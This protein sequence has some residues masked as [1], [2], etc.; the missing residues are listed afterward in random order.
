MRNKIKKIVSWLLTLVILITSPEVVK[1]DNNNNEGKMWRYLGGGGSAVHTVRFRD[2]YKEEQAQLWI[3][4]IDG[5]NYNSQNNSSYLIM[6]LEVE[7]TS[8]TADSVSYYV[9]GTIGGNTEIYAHLGTHF[10]YQ[11]GRL[12]GI[13][14]FQAFTFPLE[15]NSGYVM[16]GAVYMDLRLIGCPNGDESDRKVMYTTRGWWGRA[17]SGAD[18]V[19]GANYSVQASIKKGENQSVNYKYGGNVSHTLSTTWES[20]LSKLSGSNKQM[21]LKVGGSIANDYVSKEY[22][23][24]EDKGSKVENLNINV[25]GVK[26]LRR[27]YNSSTNELSFWYDVSLNLYNEVFIDGQSKG[28]KQ[29]EENAE[30]GIDVTNELPTANLKIDCDLDSTEDLYTNSVVTFKDTSEDYENDIVAYYLKIYGESGLVGSYEYVN[31]VDHSINN[32][33]RVDVDNERMSV[34]SAK[35]GEQKFKFLKEGP[36]QVVYN[37]IDGMYAQS[38]QVYDIY[39]YDSG[40]EAHPPVADFD[41]LSKV[42][43]GD[44]VRVTST[45]TDEDNDIVKYEWSYDYTDLPVMGEE[46]KYFDIVYNLAGVYTISHK[47]TDSTGLYDIVTKT[48]EVVDDRVV[49]PP[50]ADFECLEEIYEGETLRVTS[51][52]K[53]P[54]N[55]IVLYAWQMQNTTDMNPPVYGPNNMY[56]DIT[57][58]H[59]GRY[60]ITHTVYDSNGQSSTIT[61]SV[62]VK[63]KSD[64][65]SPPEAIFTRD[66]SNVKVG[67][68]V[69]ITSTSTDP[70]NDIVKYLWEINTNCGVVGPIY[71]END[72]YFDIKFKTSG[73][74]LVKHMVIDSTGNSDT[75]TSMFPVSENTSGDGNN[76]P[77]ADFDYKDTIRTGTTMRVTEKA[78]DLDNDIVKYEWLVEKCSDADRI[79]YS[80]DGKYVDVTYFTEG[81][82]KITLK[83]TDSR[84]NTDSV[85]KKVNVKS[86]LL[87]PPSVTIEGPSKVKKG[88]DVSLKAIAEDVDGQIV[89]YKWVLPP[90]ATGDIQGKTSGVVK[91]DNVGIATVKV[92]VKDNDGLEG[93]YTKVINVVED[94]KNPPEVRIEGPITAN[95]NKNIILAA[96]ASDSDGSIVDYD[97]EWDS[98]AIADLDGKNTGIIKFSTVGVH[99]VKVTVTDNDGLT[100]SATTA[101]TVSKAGSPPIADFSMPSSSIIGD[102]VDIWTTSTDPD[103]DIVKNEWWIDGKV[104]TELN[105]TNGGKYTFDKEGTYSIKLKV[106]DS[107]GSTDSITKTIT[108]KYLVP[109]IVINNGESELRGKQ[110]RLLILDTSKSTNHDKAGE[111]LWDETKWVFQKKVGGRYVSTND[112]KIDNTRS[113]NKAL[114]FMSKEV[115]TY[116]GTVTMKNETGGSDS[117]SIPIYILEDEAPRGEVM[118]V[119]NDK[120]LVGKGSNYVTFYTNIESYDGDYVYDFEW[121]L[122]RDDNGD[123]KFT[124]DERISDSLI[125]YTNGGRS[126]YAKIEKS[127]GYPLIKV[128]VKGTETFGGN[129]IEEYINPEDYR[130]CIVSDIVELNY[131]PEVDIEVDGDTVYEDGMIKTYYGDEIGLTYS[132]YDENTAS[133][134]LEWKV[135]SMST[136]GISY[137]DITNSSN[138]YSM[139]VKNGKIK[140]TF[141]VNGIYI[142][143]GIATDER[144]LQGKAQIKVRVYKNPVAELDDVEKYRYN[145]TVFSVKQFLRMDI[146]SNNSS[147]DDEYGD[148]WHPID[149]SKDEFTITALDKQGSDAIRVLNDTGDGRLESKSNS[150]VS[151]VAKGSRL[152]GNGYTRSFTFTKPGRYKIAYQC[153]NTYGRKSEVIYKVIN[154]VQDELPEVN[155]ESLGKYYRGE[156]G[157]PA[158]MRLVGSRA[159]DDTSKYLELNS[160]D[161]DKIEGVKVK[162]KYDKKNNNNYVLVK[163]LTE[164]Y[165][166]T[167]Y[168]L[169][170]VQGDE[171]KNLYDAYWLTKDIGKYKVEL[172]AVEVPRGEYI[173]VLL[174]EVPKNDMKKEFNMELDNQ[175]PSATYNVQKKQK[176]DVL[177]VTGNTASAGKLK[178]A[179]SVI[180]SSLNSASNNIDAQVSVKSSTDKYNY[181]MSFTQGSSG[182]GDPV[183]DN[184]NCFGDTSG[185]NKHK[186]SG[187]DLIFTGYHVSNQNDYLEG[188]LPSGEQIDVSFNVDN[189]SIYEHPGGVLM[190][191]VGGTSTNPDYDITSIKD[192]VHRPEDEYNPEGANIVIAFD[193]SRMMCVVGDKR[194]VKS[195]SKGNH[196]V[197]IVVDNET[198]TTKV[199]LNDKLVGT[200]VASDLVT[201]KF[202]VVMDHIA[203]KCDDCSSATIRNFSVKYTKQEYLTSAL[204][205]MMWRSGALKFIIYAEDGIP[206]YMEYMSSVYKKYYRTT[207]GKVLENKAHVLILGSATNSEVM[208]EFIRDVSI[209]DK[210]YMNS[211][212][213]MGKLWYNTNN[214]NTNITTMCEYIITIAKKVNIFTGYVLVDDNLTWDTKY[215]DGENDLALNNGRISFDKILAERWRFTHFENYFDNSMGKNSI[216]GIWLAD[217]MDKASKVGLYRINYKRKDN[218]F[219]PDTSISN[220]FNEYRKWSTDYD[221]EYTVGD[222]EEDK[223]YVVIKISAKDVGLGVKY[224]LLPN[225]KKIYSNEYE[226]KVYRNGRYTFKVVDYSGKESSQTIVVDSF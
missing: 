166:D 137:K 122:Y 135:Y 40:D 33:E 61:K 26:D 72:V 183:L 140:S 54:D 15:C 38:T 182:S 143:E 181:T 28:K 184:G 215:K 114:Y 60:E 173:L 16:D 46:N 66:I 25:D 102:E 70:D 62:V 14:N 207:V 23:V 85:T 120:G 152:G 131:P 83:V 55:D 52:A 47:V 219:Y 94:A 160:P 191:K 12:G 129:T 21:K 43:V 17:G 31:F 106:T 128:V 105:Y 133:T 224:I 146:H 179:K 29:A 77:I 42:S 10:K 104:F 93:E 153:V 79:V 97:W 108:V 36:Y 194:Y 45:S 156:G 71:G 80:P 188:R 30:L 91:F 147:G 123:G 20:N 197:N 56:F 113:T 87:S 212:G 138:I 110:N 144:G 48:I 225:G 196:K 205:D 39:V 112:I 132:I 157:T 198:D 8:V 5:S 141:M 223:D 222:E 74:V 125:N 37:I 63:S 65:S 18:T 119:E 57:Y 208:E 127:G 69:R 99:Y 95:V 101:I 168:S 107:E 24:T 103:N 195:V 50:V 158:E 98:S 193:N 9:E 58:L 149:F 221:G 67:D 154:V 82:Y 41:C 19:T 49:S 177:I 180:E 203:H 210:D 136:N 217:A 145:N 11:T 109:N 148:A 214:F 7:S 187:D 186:V 163:E 209:G 34:V 206:A 218:P 200:G 2:G 78:F 1:A 92:I 189:Q 73:Y 192:M 22:T 4:N 216:S 171:C 176:V 202:K 130:Y 211:D 167:T 170:K 88:E 161:G 220:P 174:D 142:I 59:A 159:A 44:T 150:K 134:K 199:Y 32:G 162:I 64:N 155:V 115:G 185:V 89:E 3:K 201:N 169:V 68:T 27:V 121:E 139:S 126:I 6:N 116:L 175:A 178:S 86:N 13:D 96:V 172:E 51:T 190:I 81:S 213:K 118:Q 164:G 75:I 165:K 53:D 100:A 90:S 226:Y 124:S 204:N 151:F 84:G 76:P 35:A 117:K 111:M